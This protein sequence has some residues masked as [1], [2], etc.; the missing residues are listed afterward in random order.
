MSG[1]RS[2]AVLLSACLALGSL[3]IWR[4]MTL[5]RM[6]AE[7]AAA[8]EKTVRTRA[9]KPV[10]AGRTPAPAARAVTPHAG[11]SMTAADDSKDPDVV[12]MRDSWG[13]RTSRDMYHDLELTLNLPQEKLA[14]LDELVFERYHKAG[15]DALDA[16]KAVGITD[17]AAITAAMRQARAEVDQQIQALL[18]SQYAQWLKLYEISTDY[19]SVAG[20][21]APDMS[22]AGVPMTPEQKVSLAVAIHEIEGSAVA[23]GVGGRGYRLVDQTAWLA[24]RD[25]EVLAGAEQF[26]SREQVEVLA[27]SLMIGNK[28]AALASR[29]RKAAVR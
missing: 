24:I 5:S 23:A 22:F 25:R 19:A 8:K 1:S 6:R 2:T 16:S 12:R 27:Q 4:G 20:K 7:V 15:A 28:E 21:Y 29:S 10:P 11:A 17:T 9:R 26:L 18:G 13:R 14:K 3:N